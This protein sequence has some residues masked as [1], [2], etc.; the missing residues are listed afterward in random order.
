MPASKRGAGKGVFTEY[1]S[2]NAEKPACRNSKATGSLSRSD[3]I[4][5]P[6]PAMTSIAGRILSLISVYFS[7]T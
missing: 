6:P 2:E 3:T 7:R 1:R 5:Y 4:L